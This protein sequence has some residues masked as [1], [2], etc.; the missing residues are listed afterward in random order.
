MIAPIH[1]QQAIERTLNALAIATTKP[2]SRGGIR[3]SGGINEPPA[4]IG[5][6]IMWGKRLLHERARDWARMIG[7][8]QQIVIDADPDDVSVL[9]WLHKQAH[10][11]AA[12]SEAQQFL[13]EL[14]EATK[15]IENPYLP[16]SGKTY[17]GHHGGG[18]VYVKEHQQ[19]VELED[20]RTETVDSI[21]AWNRDQMRLAE[22][23]AKEV[24]EIIWEFFGHYIKPRLIADTRNNDANPRSKK[25]NKLESIRKEG[26]EHIY[27]VQDV[28]NRLSQNESTGIV[29]NAHKV[30]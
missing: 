18:N 2:G 11:I 6:G 9:A 17:I 15:M 16:R 20:G 10:H 28:L 22:G 26:R 27:R 25:E 8:E 12:H 5:E 30:L 24:A 7:D 4:P 1:V 3:V 13:D 29:D 23:T 14:T 19:T 21:R